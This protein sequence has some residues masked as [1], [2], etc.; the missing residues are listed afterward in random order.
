M[1]YISASLHGPDVASKKP[2]LKYHI[3]RERQDGGDACYALDGL[4]ELLCFTGP[5][6]LKMTVLIECTLHHFPPL[7]TSL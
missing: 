7:I 3:T 5:V 6:E 2:G 4:V 1:E